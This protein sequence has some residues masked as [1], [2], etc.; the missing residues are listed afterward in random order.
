MN[1]T[2][3]TSGVSATFNH[4]CGHTCAGM[5]YA[6]EQYAQHDQARQESNICW[7]CHNKREIA[8]YQQARTT[9]TK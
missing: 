2:P 3:S 6:A 5:F 1:I 4:T 8:R 9:T 7:S